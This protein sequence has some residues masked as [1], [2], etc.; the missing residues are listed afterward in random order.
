MRR[1]SSLLLVL[2]LAAAVCAFGQV[3]DPNIGIFDPGASCAPTCGLHPNPIPTNEFG[4]WNFGNAGNGSTPW[5]LILALPDFAGSAPS[6]TSDSSSPDKFTATNI[7]LT[8]SKF[9]PA[10]GSLYDFVAPA[11]GGLTGNSSMSSATMFPPTAPP[12][13]FFDVF[14]FSM[15]PVS[16]ATDLPPQVAELF[17]TS[18]IA[19][20]FV[21]AVGTDSKGQQ[22]STPFTTAGLAHSSSTTS[23]TTST[24]TS[25]PGGGPASGPQVPEPSG[26]VL[27]GTALLAASAGLRKKLVRS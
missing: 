23:T 10:S 22:F 8:D 20:S 26:I 18:L 24:S 9:L 1:S 6:L 12:P 14:V 16:P 19:G 3:L 27:L 17:D 11:T 15:S 5:F 25:G 4:V 13:S 2:A 7:L 21:A